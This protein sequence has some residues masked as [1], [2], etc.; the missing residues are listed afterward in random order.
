MS[1][2]PPLDRLPNGPGSA[3]G[4]DPGRVDVGM[5]QVVLH[6]SQVAVLLVEP[7]A[8][9]VPERVQAS[10]LDAQALAESPEPLVGPAGAVGQ[11][12][13]RSARGGGLEGV[14]RSIAPAPPL[15]GTTP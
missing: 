8:S 9:R 5:A 1:T 6:L 12:E 10:G 15:P 14:S 4:V 2:S 7:R 13:A 3:A 11:H